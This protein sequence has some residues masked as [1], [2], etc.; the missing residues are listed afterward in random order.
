MPKLRVFSDLVA[1]CLHSCGFVCIR[2][3][4][5]VGGLIGLELNK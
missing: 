2:I 4:M 1:L 3:G 5:C